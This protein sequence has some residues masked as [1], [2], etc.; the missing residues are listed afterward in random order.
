M[1]GLIC[2]KFRMDIAPRSLLHVG[3]FV[4]LTLANANG[5]MLKFV[6]WENDGAVTQDY[7]S[8][9]ISSL[10]AHRPESVSKPDVVRD[11]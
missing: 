9:R 7:L 8:L 5:Q 3:I 2:M 4:F 6:R 10:C 1:T 11:S